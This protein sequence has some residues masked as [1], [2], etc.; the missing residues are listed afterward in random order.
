MP[1]EP[2]VTVRV[3]ELSDVDQI[4]DLIVVSARALSRDYYK[5]EQIEA[6]IAHVFGVDTTLI[7]DATYFVAEEKGELVGCGG[8]SKRRTLFG[9]DQYAARDPGLADPARDAARI[10]AFF[11][12][13]KLARQG[14]GRTLLTRC[15]AEAR[16]AGY[17]SAELMSTLPG[18]SFYET[19]GY[20]PRPR[21][22]FTVGEDVEIEFVPMRKVF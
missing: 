13:P 8:W 6:A 2:K 1:P 7:A 3:A 17:K 20:L 21:T 5:S 15:E 9:G 16:A 14:V 11:V 12:H 18:V 22:T 19:N 10:R 4:R